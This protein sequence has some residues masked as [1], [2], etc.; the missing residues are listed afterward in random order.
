MSVYR[1]GEIEPSKLYICEQG[2]LYFAM[3]D[4]GNRTENYVSIEELIKNLHRFD[5]SIYSLH[6]KIDPLRYV[7]DHVEKIKNSKQETMFK[8][9]KEINLPRMIDA[10]KIEYPEEFI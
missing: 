2:S 1:L 10:V 6:D 7:R 9:I 4:N 3:L 8:I 5:I